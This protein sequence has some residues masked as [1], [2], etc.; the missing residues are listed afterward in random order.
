MAFQ[1]LKGKLVLT[2]H[3]CSGKVDGFENENISAGTIVFV[4]ECDETWSKVI[5]SQRVLI[6]PTEY[7]IV[8]K[9]SKSLEGKTFCFTGQL[10]KTRDYYQAF[11]S[12]H[13][14]EFRSSVTRDLNYLVMADPNSYSSKAV[15]AKSYGTKCI[16]EKELLK[17]VKV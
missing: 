2:T 5:N 8:C 3:T 4:A 10:D 17:M 11:I 15:K 12:L 14:G 16:S 7:L 1:N 9:P 6:V 13:A